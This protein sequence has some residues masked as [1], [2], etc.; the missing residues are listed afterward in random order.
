MG[1]P[2]HPFRFW[3]GSWEVV[4]ADDG[5]PAA[6]NEIEEVL[7]GHAFL[8]HWASP[9]GDGKSL[10]YWHG[11]TTEWR[12]VWVTAAGGVKEKRLLERLDDGGVRFQGRVGKVLDR[13]TLRPLDAGRVSQLIEV[14]EDEGRT[15]RAT[16]DAVYVPAAA[17]AAA[18]AL[19]HSAAS[20]PE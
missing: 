7:D 17:R 14:S 10:F 2:P 1:A 16:F 20:G 6:R 12:Q 5:E 8:E 3:V 15:W 9:Y 13:T 19:R 18:S 11:P 4:A